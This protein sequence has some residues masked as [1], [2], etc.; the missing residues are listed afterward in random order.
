M[1]AV[2]SAVPFMGRAGGASSLRIDSPPARKQWIAIFHAQRFSPRV[3]TTKRTVFV[4]GEP[5][6]STHETLRMAV[7]FP[8]DVESSQVWWAILDDTQN[9]NL[10]TSLQFGNCGLRSDTATGAV[11]VVDEVEAELHKAGQRYEGTQPEG[12]WSMAA[13]IET[14]SATSTFLVNNR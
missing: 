4:L 14:L 1:P 2:G 6:E 10:R 5:R 3:D 8:L 11:R 9:R 7:A 12:S 13:G